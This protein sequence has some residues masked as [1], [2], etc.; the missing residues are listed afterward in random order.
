[1]WEWSKPGDNVSM[2]GLRIAC[3]DADQ[4]ARQDTQDALENAGHGTVGCKSVA[5]AADLVSAGDIDC[6]VTEYSLPDGTGLDLTAEIRER[7][8][9]TPCILFTDASPERIASARHGDVVV[10]YL[11]RDTPEAEAS[12]VRLVENVVGQR[13]QVGYPLPPDEDERLAALA[14]YDRPEL[15]AVD[16]F[17]RLTA[18]A[19]EH[20]CTD[21]AFVGLVDAHEERF[22]ACTGADWETLTREDSMCTHTIL[23]DE[24]LV[25]KDVDADPRFADNDRLDELDIAAYV[26]VP[27]RTPRGATVGAFCLTNGE[28]RSFSADDREDLRRF[29]T[30][31]M[32]QLELRRRLAEAGGDAPGGSA[33]SAADSAGE[34]GLAE[35]GATPGPDGGTGA[36]GEGR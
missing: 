17:D 24:M 11:P 2:P 19:R 1:M 10:E 30:E 5:E 9:D 28:P 25:V 13:S 3:V 15:A 12:L 7:T 26:G 8:P 22:L 6:V 32:D 21:V 29:A 16:A 23:E 4:D 36:G 34:S 31:A 14:Q 27:L 20:F 33:E 35:G 18:L